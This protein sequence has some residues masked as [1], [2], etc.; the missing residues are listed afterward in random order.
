MKKHLFKLSWLLF[1]LLMTVGL[2]ACKKEEEPQEETEE[3]VEVEEEP[4]VEEEEEPEVIP[5]NQNLLTGLGDLSEEA[6]GKR[7]VAIMVNNIDDAMPQYGV[8]QA[9]VIFELPVEGDLT[10]FMALYGDYTQVPKVCAIRSCRYYYP[11][12]SEGFDAFYVFWGMDETKRD[13]VESLNLTY[14]DG[15]VY[16]NGLFGRD[17]ARRNAGYALEHTAYFDGTKFASV[18][19][20]KGLRSD[21]EEDKT[22]TAFLFNGMSEQLKAEG[23]D[24]TK[25]NVEFGRATATFTYDEAT[26]TY[27]KQLNGKDQVD[28]VE[29]TQLAFTNVF[30]LETDISVRTDTNEGH[31]Q[32][33]WKGGENYVGY[34]ISNGAV[35]KIS[36]SKDSEESYLKFYDESGEE[37]SIN[38]GKSYIAF[39]YKGQTTFE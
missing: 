26:K 13:Y 2:A 34:Y 36:W 8:A 15:M 19:D 31:K 3:V 9:D 4:I 23:E 18:V 7:P 38:R 27:L 17:N 28:G 29:N 33:N 39:N 6:I 37:L 20:S 11:A 16:G 22:G 25:V 5:E 14:F 10:R 12:I 35:Q 1:V 24:C 30:V 21:L 32:I